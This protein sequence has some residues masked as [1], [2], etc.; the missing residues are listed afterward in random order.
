MSACWAKLATLGALTLLGACSA[1]VDG[2]LGE[3]RCRDEGVVGAPAC[4]DGMVC[5]GGVC[6]KAPRT[7]RLGD[8]CTADEDCGEGLCVLTPEGGRCTKTCC[9]SSD[10][11]DAG[12][13]FVCSSSSDGTRLCQP[14]LGRP[15]GELRAGAICYSDDGCRS[16]ACV[17]SRCA[18]TCCADTSCLASASPSVCR[19]VTDAWVCQAPPDGAIGRYLDPCT[20]DAE[21]ASGLCLLIGT[22][23]LCSRPCCGSAACGAT[24]EG[25]IGCGQAPHGATFVSACSVLLTAE[26]RGEIG[27]ACV[28]DAQCR[29]GLCD[30]ASGTCSDRCCVDA[31]CGDS[32][33]V[34]AQAPGALGLR[35]GTK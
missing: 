2:E 24:A 7:P 14:T 28:S 12:E 29:S 6:S 31:D 32:A 9:T 18:D 5:A 10:C 4:P 13:G 33:R 34:C 16:G 8:A 35:C 30:S 11:G 22:A 1:I 25:P 27:S 15:L 3:V 17:G 21:C 23:T 20:A 26:A 19:A